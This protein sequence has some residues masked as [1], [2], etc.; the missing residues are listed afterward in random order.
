MIEGGSN[1]IN[2]RTASCDDNAFLTKLVFK[3][4][5]SSDGVIFHEGTLCIE[6]GLCFTKFDLSS[7]NDIVTVGL[8]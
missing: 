1:S 8:T 2:Q 6:R 5:R 7:V 4:P 3:K